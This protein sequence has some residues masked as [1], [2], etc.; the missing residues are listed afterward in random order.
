MEAIGVKRKMAFEHEGVPYLCLDVEVSTQTARDGQTLRM[1]L[2][3][4]AGNSA[5]PKWGILRHGGK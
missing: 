1:V 2:V 3:F 5:M 4:P